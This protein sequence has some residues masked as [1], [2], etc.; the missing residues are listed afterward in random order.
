MTPITEASRHIESALHRALQAFADAPVGVGFSGGLDSTA[1]LLATRSLQQSTQPDLQVNAIHVNHNLHAHSSAWVNHCSQ[2]CAQ[3]N[4]PITVASVTVPGLGNLEANARRVRYRAFAKH[5]PSSGVLLLGHH[6]QDQSETILYRLLQG[7]GM[8]TI[9]PEGRLGRG[10]FV[11]PLLEVPREM[12]RS[13]VQEHGLSWVEDP[14]NTDTQLH[15]N[16]LR[17][18][19]LPLLKTRW[20]D[21]DKALNRVASHH[22]QTAAALIDTLA[23]LPDEIPEYKLPVAPARR[24]AW[25]RAYL[26]SRSVFSVSDRAL[27]TFIAQQEATDL[28]HLQ[29]GDADIYSYNDIFYFES[30]RPKPPAPALLRDGATITL[31]YGTLSLHQAQAGETMAFPAELPLKLA[32]RQ[33]GET[34]RS[35]SQGAGDSPGLTRS[36]KQLLN[37]ARVPPWRRDSYPL[38][39]SGND[40]VCVPGVAVA[41]R[42]GTAADDSVTCWQARFESRQFDAE[43]N[44]KK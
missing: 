30:A 17:A 19:V 39:Y 38:I 13:Y 40:L 7:R 11:R 20:A 1:L 14:T 28:A 41:S 15:R 26:A 21:L 12:L 5:L 16:F 27:D 43:Q 33:G 35:S 23:W 9:R 44:G 36:L 6:E 42:A 37:E 32:F 3:L 34:L 8:L 4:V 10:H 29:L 18:D 22:N 25:L 24:R 2:V 31:P